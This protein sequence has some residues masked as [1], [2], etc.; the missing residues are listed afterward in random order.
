MAMR[1]FEVS[2][3]IGATPAQVWQNLTDAR[4]LT[5]SG[6]GVTKI[7]GSIGPGEKF[8]LWSEVAPER[9]FSLRVTAFE[10]ERRMVWEGGMPLG[11]FQGIRTFTLLASSGGASFT[12]REDYKGPFAPL[13]LRS[14]PDLNP[15]FEKFAKGLQA[16]SEGRAT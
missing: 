7:E 9:A 3:T 4:R 6:L 2:R 10:P 13:I 14:M 11:L 8:K 16:L 15:S 1:F 12:M 5:S